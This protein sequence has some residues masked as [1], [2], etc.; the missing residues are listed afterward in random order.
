MQRSTVSLRKTI[1]REKT[2]D[3]TSSQMRLENKFLSQIGQEWQFQQYE[4]FVPEDNMDGCVEASVS[5]D[6]D[7]K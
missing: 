6:P 2:K 3:P 4:W 1:P 5:V 7:C